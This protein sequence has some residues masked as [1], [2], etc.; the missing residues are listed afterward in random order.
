MWEEVA[1]QT[2][3][4]TV[5]IRRGVIAWSITSRTPDTVTWA[6][7]VICV[8]FIQLVRTIPAKHARIETQIWTKLQHGQ[9]VRPEEYGMAKMEGEGGSENPQ[10]VGG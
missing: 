8:D 3:T 5:R 7:I 9:I 2:K 10:G 1:V 6:A 4:A